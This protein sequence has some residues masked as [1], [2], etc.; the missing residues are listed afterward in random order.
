MESRHHPR[1]RLT[2]PL[3]VSRVEELS[4]TSGITSFGLPVLRRPGVT[5]S[6]SWKC[7]SRSIVRGF[8]I[9]MR[10]PCK[11]LWGMGGRNQAILHEFA[12]GPTGINEFDHKAAKPRVPHPQLWHPWL[13]I[14]TS[15]LS[16]TPSRTPTANCT[17]NFPR[18]DIL[19]SQDPTSYNAIPNGLPT[20]P[21]LH[22]RTTR[23]QALMPTSPIISCILY[24][25][26]RP[27]SCI[28]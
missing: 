28:V 5:L 22:L 25:P 3:S 9:R 10:V 7:S 19:T 24:P 2:T 18:F 15:S 6:R 17:T 4:R 11:D 12:R 8:T 1:S 14:C 20:S 26:S 21:I 23:T 16:Y 13:R 27:A